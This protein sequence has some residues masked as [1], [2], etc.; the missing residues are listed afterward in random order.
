[1]MAPEELA[2][3]NDWKGRT[4][5][6]VRTRWG[7]F[8]GPLDAVRLPDGHYAAFVEL[9][10]E[11]GPILEREQIPIGVVTAIAAPASLWVRLEGEGGHA[12]TVLM[13]DRK[14]A[15]CAAAE[16]A[17][18]VESAAR[19]G[20]SP[21]TVATTGHLAVQPGAINSIPDRVTLGIDVR[22]IDLAPRD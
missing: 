9:H 12:G 2:T 10:I 16:V 18:A 15:L 14:D 7:G 17:L 20:G 19:A 3:L 21:D 22:D 8:E 5:D 6:E 13:P 1:A 4:F 11:Q